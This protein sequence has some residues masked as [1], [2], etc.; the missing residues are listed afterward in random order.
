MRPRRLVS[1]LL[2][3][4]VAMLAAT[5]ATAADDK[6]QDAAATPRFTSRAELVLVPAIVTERGGAHV[7]G[8]TKNDFVV[9]DNGVEQTIATFEEIKASS[10]P[11]HRAPAINATYTNQL[12]SGGEARRINILAI[13]LINTPIVDQEVAKAELIKFL[14]RSAGSNQLT[15]VLAL[16]PSG[17]KVVHDF[18]SD[19][20]ILIAALKKLR[21]TPHVMAGENTEA[22]AEAAAGLTLLNT[23]NADPTKIMLTEL[24]RATEAKWA[25]MA[26][27]SAVHT[28]LDAFRDIAHAYSGVPGRKALIWIT[29]SFPFVIEKVM[30]SME[31]QPSSA[32][33]GFCL[34]DRIDPNSFGFATRWKQIM[35]ELNAANISVYPVD[36]RGLSVRGFSAASTN[37]ISGGGSKKTDAGF[38]LDLAIQYQSQ[39]DAHTATLDTMANIAEM[40]GG[41]AFYNTNDIATAA[42]R[43]ADDSSQYYVLGFYRK[44]KRGEKPNWHA[45]QV[46]V[47]REHAAIRAR[48]GYLVTENVTAEQTLR[49]DLASVVSS[50]FDFSGVPLWFRVNDQTASGEPGGKKQVR[51]VIGLNPGAFSIDADSNNLVSLEFVVIARDAKMQM[52]DQRN[53]HMQANLNAETMAKVTTDGLTYQNQLVL[54][55]GD[56]S[57]RVAVRDNVTGRMGSLQAPLRV[58]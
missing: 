51:F 15:T 10:A 18:T 48:S 32:S 53:R 29:G 23:F 9:R 24:V 22:E 7:S 13:D 25:Q 20:R 1:A 3:L 45:L 12:T 35:E 34:C 50:P 57:V 19:T 33:N 16:S 52:A 5:L 4:A 46:K 8:L 39:V 11:V 2:L 54:A 21:G 42:E 44:P 28:T 47:K 38:A 41:R 14:E 36:A 30:P 56:Y 43:A 31:S 6:K 58:E 55:P 26:R 37:P 40:T 27:A 49:A 17:F